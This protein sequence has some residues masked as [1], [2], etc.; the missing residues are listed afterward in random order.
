MYTVVADREVARIMVAL[1]AAATCGCVTHECIFVCVC[2]CVCV[3]VHACMYE[4]VCLD[5]VA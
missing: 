5:V 2:V 3:R 4:D 1:V